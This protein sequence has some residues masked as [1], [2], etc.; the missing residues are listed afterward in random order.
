L[1]FLKLLLHQYYITVGCILQH[2]RK[3]L[4]NKH[5]N[6][7]VKAPKLLHLW[8]FCFVFIYNSASTQSKNLGLPSIIN[9]E[10]HDYDSGSE[11][12]GISFQGN[13]TLFAN[14]AGLLVYNGSHWNTYITPLNTILRS[15][16]V[17]ND[18]IWIGGQSELGF[19]IPDE[20]GSLIYKSITEPFIELNYNLGEIWDLEYLNGVLYLR[21]D[22]QFIYTYKDGKVSQ[23]ESHTSITNLSKVD[24]ELLIA[25][26]DQGIYRIKLDNTLEILQ[27]TEDFIAEGIISSKHGTFLLTKES[28]IYLYTNNEVR[29]WKTNV[30]NYLKEKNIKCGV[31]DDKLGLLIG[32][33]FGGFVQIDKAGRALHVLSK[34]NGLL[35]NDINKLAI[36]SDMSIWLATQNGVDRFNIDSGQSIF[37]PDGELQGAVYDIKKWQGKLFFCTSNG[38]YH[39]EDKEYYNPLQDIQFTLVEG[40]VGQTWGLDIID[41]EMFLAHHTG[42]YHV[43]KDL[44]AI[45]ILNEN[46]AWKFVKIDKNLIAVGTYSGVYLINKQNNRWKIKSYISGLEESCRVMVHDK[47]NN[48]WI[49]HPYK[50]VYKIT[51]SP[52]YKSSSIKAYDGD[53]GLYTNNR[54]YV[55]SVENDCIVTNET[56]VYIYNETADDFDKYPA[57]DTIFHS[58]I[59]LK[60]ILPNDDDNY[61]I[62]ASNGT[63]QYSKAPLREF[64]EVNSLDKSYVDLTNFI[65]G[66]ENLYVSDS[67]ALFLCTIK[68]VVNVSIVDKSQQ[69][70]APNITRISLPSQRDS[71]VYGGFSNIPTLQ[72]AQKETAILFEFNSSQ[73]IPNHETLY[74]H[75]LEGVDEWSVPSTAQTQEYNNLKHGDYT[76]KVKSLNPNGEFSEASIVKFNIV[77]PWYLSLIAKAIYALLAL[78]IILGLFLIPRQQYQKSTAILET[79]KKNTEVEMQTLR[80]ETERELE[81]IKREQLETEILFKNKELAMSTMHLLQK[82]QTL[83]AIRAEV[84]KSTSKIK[85]PI[86]KKEVKK[87]ISLLRNDDRLEDDWSNFSVHFDQAHHNFLKRIK[88]KYPQLTPKDQKLCAYLRMNLTTKEIAPLLNISVRGV[89][90]AR[91]RLRKKIDLDKEKNLNDFMMEF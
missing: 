4:A 67:L 6:N 82:N 79:E 40:T 61:W 66:F 77:T 41:D 16:T 85:D 81:T 38:L 20:S 43:T 71:V 3:M 65:G 13:K 70:E 23:L 14:Q 17:V 91:Y 37:Y 90:I 15:I 22:T 87:I 19:F 24:N 73:D 25:L 28:G 10:K 35:S 18:T 84:E 54:N 1:L 29:P 31:Y 49:S 26:K 33:K 8:I 56:G 9:Y 42:A 45:P 88:A 27:N 63:R 72:L 39:I 5:N 55:F 50:K 64:V 58:N 53:D 52:D 86:A 75:V 83:T 46:G 78:M 30:D 36:A 21:S 74:S 32:T 48:L 11:N 69:I 7:F 59:H 2:T 68:G 57:L 89:E 62:I 47:Y 76:F 60:R 44:K 12:W 34:R 80:R 51:F